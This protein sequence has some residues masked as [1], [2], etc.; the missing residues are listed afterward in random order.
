M[1][2]QQPTYGQLEQRYAKLSKNI[3]E[4]VSLHAQVFIRFHELSLEKE[5]ISRE[6]RAAYDERKNKK[7]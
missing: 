5:R 1:Y 4:F 3:S 6:M 2:D 7:Q